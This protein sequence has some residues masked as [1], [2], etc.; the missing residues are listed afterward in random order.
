MSKNDTLSSAS[1]KTE[2]KSKMLTLV[3]SVVEDAEHLFGLR[4]VKLT[5]VFRQCLEDDNF[6][7]P[8]RANN[9]C[10]INPADCEE[11]LSFSIFHFFDYPE[12]PEE[13]FNRSKTFELE[14]IVSSG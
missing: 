6:L 13:F 4:T 8:E 14:Y 12:E 10:I 11:G 9:D 3:S 5:L 2:S 7:K 1:D